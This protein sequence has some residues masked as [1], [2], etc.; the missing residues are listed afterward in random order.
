MTM[1]NLPEPPPFCYALDREDNVWYRSWT[2]WTLNTRSS[3]REGPIAYEDIGPHLKPFRRLF[4]ADQLLQMA[5]TATA[6]RSDIPAPE[7]EPAPE[8]ETEPSVPVGEPEANIR[9]TEGGLT[10][11]RITTL[12]DEQLTDYIGMV[13]ARVHTIKAE[14]EL[15]ETTLAVLRPRLN[16]YVVDL[17][18]LR[19]EHELRNRPPATVEVDPPTTVEQALS[20]PFDSDAG[21][22]LTLREYLGRL[23]VTVWKEEE[24]F[25]GKHPFGNSGWQSDV[26]VALVGAGLI[27]GHVEDEGYL[28]SYDEQG[29]NALVI[30][31]IELM[32]KESP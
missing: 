29:F 20:T 16:I 26:A 1:T 21:D 25:S 10:R 28:G 12:T 22:G 13:Q 24:G 15:R 6:A 19:L 30:D 2:T 3:D 31:A 18:D 8:T 23:L 27:A 32:T 5:N 4:T 7:A 14:I 9:S 17:A 11:Y